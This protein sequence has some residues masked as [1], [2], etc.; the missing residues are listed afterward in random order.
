MHPGLRWIERTAVEITLAVS[1]KLS[2][3]CSTDEDHISR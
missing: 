1:R 3:A 2:L